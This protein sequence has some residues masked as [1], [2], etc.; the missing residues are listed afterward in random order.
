M[1]PFPLHKQAFDL[2][3]HKATKELFLAVANKKSILI[4]GPSGSGKTSL[5]NANEK[6]IQDHVY[7]YANLNNK[8]DLDNVM[9]HKGHIIVDGL[10]SGVRK[11]NLPRKDTVEIFLP[12]S[13]GKRTNELTYE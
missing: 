5:I 3:M 2:Q 4:Y 13:M 10:Y 12:L 6:L 11:L 1:L 9:N 8:K 7:I